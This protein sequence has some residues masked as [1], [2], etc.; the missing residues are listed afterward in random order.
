MQVQTKFQS[1]SSITSVQA[2]SQ[3]EGYKHSSRVGPLTAGRGGPARAGNL[4]EGAKMGADASRST[5]RG[6][7]ARP[8]RRVPHA[9]QD[10]TYHS[11]HHAHTGHRHRL[12]MPLSK[13]TRPL[14]TVKLLARRVICAS[15]NVRFC[16]CQACSITIRRDS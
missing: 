4:F 12:V 13:T 5:G 14:T 2:Q 8:S 16:S 7:V 15:C 9:E 11:R 6:L 3:P 1:L 10:F